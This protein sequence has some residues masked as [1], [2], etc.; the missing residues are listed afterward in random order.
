MN[1][2]LTAKIK[3]AIIAGFTAAALTTS[4]YGAEAYDDLTQI[5]DLTDPG[6][7]YMYDHITGE[8]KYLPP[9]DINT[10][11]SGTEGTVPSYDPHSD[12]QK[13]AVPPQ[14]LTQDKRDENET[15]DNIKSFRVLGWLKKADMDMDLNEEV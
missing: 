3:S 6:G 11:S 8:V 12:K 15:A 1:K 4:A 5:S 9:S 10:Y 13:P 2:E 14:P 7:A